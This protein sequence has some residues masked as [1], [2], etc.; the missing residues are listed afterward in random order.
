MVSRTLTVTVGMKKSFYQ[1]NVP[2]FPRASLSAKLVIFF[3]RTVKIAMVDW[4]LA[5]ELFCVRL[6]WI[7]EKPFGFGFRQDPFG[8]SEKILSDDSRYCFP[9]TSHENTLFC[10]VSASHRCDLLS[11]EHPLMS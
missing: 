8:E 9:T 2:D 4:L 5:K 6:K 3:K 1:S 11:T 7:E 10:L